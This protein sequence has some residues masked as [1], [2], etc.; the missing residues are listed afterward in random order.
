[1]SH[2]IRTPMN[3]ILGMIG[4]LRETELTSEQESYAQAADAS[5]RTLMSI[6]DEILDTSKIESGRLDLERSPFDLST[7]AESV[8]ELL[9][10]R[11]HAKGIEIS[12]RVT[13]NVPA[14][15]I[16]DE[17]RTRQILFNTLG[18]QSSSPNRAAW[19][20]SLTMTAR[21][22][23]WRWMFRHGHRICRQS[24]TTISLMNMRR[25]TATRRA[26]LAER[27][28]DFQSAKTRRRHGWQDHRVEQGG[29]WFKILHH[30]SLCQGRRRRI[31]GKPLL[32]R[33]YELAAPPGPIRQ[34]LEPSSWKSEQW[35]AFSQAPKRF[36]RHFRPRAATDRRF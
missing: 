32:A 33:T 7:L 18:N 26:V 22:K 30:P 8:T 23:H 2:E 12:C 16:G 6:I 13:S 15:I 5:G 28:W 1:M 9:A 19:R 21:P 27:G 11:A 24:E 10:P 25:P 34:H 29:A 20:C 4:L 17:T 14:I 3:G 35:C 31:A 36:V